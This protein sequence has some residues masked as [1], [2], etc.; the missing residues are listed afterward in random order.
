MMAAELKILASPGVRAA[1]NQLAPG[2]E[3]S[4]GHKVVAS[5]DVIAVIKRRID[6]GEPF[7]VVVP[8]PELIDELVQHGK[9][10]A[11]SKTAFARTGLGIAIVKGAPRPDTASV[12]GFKRALLDAKAVGHSKEGASGTN[13]LIVLEQLGIAEAMRPKLY[14][15]SG[16]NPIQE[17]KAELVVTGMGP[18]ME[19]A[20]ADFVGGLP[21]GVQRYVTFAAG[22]SATTEQP[23]A[24]RDLLRYLTA[25]S[26]AAAVFKAMG[27]ER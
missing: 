1:V 17:G 5:Y 9:V 22:V 11:D 27:L 6:A 16:G 18:A 13:F 3:R 10:A 15:S 14:A 4:T 20:G 21:A 8:G 23:D 24:A 19:M 26:D 2:F 7:D 25:S 12:E